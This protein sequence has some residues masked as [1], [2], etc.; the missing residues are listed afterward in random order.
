VGIFTNGFPDPSS[1]PGIGNNIT[2]TEAPNGGA[3]KTTMAITISLVVG[4]SN[5]VYP[6]SILRP[7]DTDTK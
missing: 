1:T 3:T 6:V 7:A 5:I 2:V 4:K